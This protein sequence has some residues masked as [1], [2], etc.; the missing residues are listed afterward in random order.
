MMK[1]I[2]IS[3]SDIKFKSWNTFIIKNM[4]LSKMWTLNRQEQGV[5]GEGMTGYLFNL[6]FY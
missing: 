1:E 4:H 2:P 3:L 6:H 5:F